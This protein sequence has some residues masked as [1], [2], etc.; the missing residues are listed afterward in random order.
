MAATK[1]QRFRADGCSHVPC[2]VAVGFITTVLNQLCDDAARAEERA[3]AAEDVLDLADDGTL[4]NDANEG[5]RAQQRQVATSARALA[6]E[7]E[8]CLS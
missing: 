3:S 1:L 5:A 2:S 7:M 4:E 6:D 8:V